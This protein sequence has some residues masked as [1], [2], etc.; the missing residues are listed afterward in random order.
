MAE[1]VKAEQKK[2]EKKRVLDHA[3]ARIAAEKEESAAHVVKSMKKASENEIKSEKDIKTAIAPGSG[4]VS[5]SPKPT[6]VKV[7]SPA[8][9]YLV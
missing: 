3:Y 2:E 5:S 8:R 6:V 9:S 1:K 4:A 7:R